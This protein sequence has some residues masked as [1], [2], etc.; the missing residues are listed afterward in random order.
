MLPHLVIGVEYMPTSFIIS[1]I[2]NSEVIIMK[3]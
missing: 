3:T 1:Y 2:P